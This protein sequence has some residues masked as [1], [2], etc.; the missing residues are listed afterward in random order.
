[1]A[2]V[3]EVEIRSRVPALEELTGHHKR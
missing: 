2:D 3:H 1:M